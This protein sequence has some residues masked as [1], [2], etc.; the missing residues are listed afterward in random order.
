MHDTANLLSKP[1]I[2]ESPFR[3]AEWNYFL[4]ETDRSALASGFPNN[5]PLTERSHGS[6]KTYL[7]A[8]ANLQSPNDPC[9]EAPNE[10]Y[11][12][13]ERLVSSTSYRKALEAVAGESLLTAQIEI[14][15][16]R[17]E[18]GFFMS[19]HTDSANKIVTHIIYLSNSWS[20]SD[21]G[22]LRLIS[23]CKECADVLIVPRWPRSVILPRAENSWHEVTIVNDR[24]T[25][26]RPAIQV[27]FWRSKPS[28]VAA[29]RRSWEAK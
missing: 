13:L 24:A 2:H 26:A 25:A 18:A 4:T 27:S 22:L 7:V 14:A 16:T 5:I 15:L 6:D 20:K 1:L 10:S 28:S 19:P 3:W 12:A 29:G 23:H 21:G 8:C 11:A 17:Y 9:V